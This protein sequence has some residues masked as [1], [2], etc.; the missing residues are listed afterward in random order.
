MTG[1]KRALT[2]KM[3]LRTQ[4]FA[5][6]QVKLAAVKNRLDTNKNPRGRLKPAGSGSL[7]KN[8]R[9]APTTPDRA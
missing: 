2:K 4:W 3:P 8:S 1:I 7:A 9:G 5:L 6:K